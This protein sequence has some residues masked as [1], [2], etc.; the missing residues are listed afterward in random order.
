MRFYINGHEWML[1][2]VS[3]ND[4]HLVKEDGTITLGMTNRD[5][6]TVYVSDALNDFMTHKVISHELV[7]VAC[8]EY[9]YTVSRETEEL[10]ADFLATYGREI[11]NV[12]DE[13]TGRIFKR[14]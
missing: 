11:L 9:G 12:A 13:I 3:K 10:I 7:H 5:T 4:F 1:H 8:L 2:F 6:K 14:A